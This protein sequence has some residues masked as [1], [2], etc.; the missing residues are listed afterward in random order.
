MAAAARFHTCKPMHQTAWSAH[1][2]VHD[3]SMRS[4]FESRYCYHGFLR[5]EMLGACSSGLAFP[6]CQGSRQIDLPDL[7]GC[8]GDGVH[9]G[10]SAHCLLDM[11]AADG[12]N[13]LPILPRTLP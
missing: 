1:R 4:Y 3:A 6:G 13:G 12:A 8:D 11:L 2:I 7:R 5:L 9:A 10:L